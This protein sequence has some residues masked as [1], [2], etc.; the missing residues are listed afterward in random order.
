[1]SSHFLLKLLRPSRATLLN[2]DTALA[3][4]GEEQDVLAADDAEL[5]GLRRMRDRFLQ[6][7]RVLLG[8]R[9]LH[10]AATGLG[11]MALAVVG[12]VLSVPAVHAAALLALGLVAFPVLTTL[13]LVSLWAKR[14]MASARNR[15]ARNFYERGLR[16]DGQGRVVTNAAYPRVIVAA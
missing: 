12:F 10:S 6:S 15:I 11:L 16:V 13:S 3:Y 14:R 1:M 7:E 8:L 5:H 4:I 9:L 2:G